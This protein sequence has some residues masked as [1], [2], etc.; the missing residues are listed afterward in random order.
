M[1]YV[2]SGTGQLWLNNQALPMRAGNLHYVKAGTIKAIENT[3]ATEPLV[4]LAYLALEADKPVLEF[5][6]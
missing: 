2:I 3:S 5:V 6:D 4:V 1:I